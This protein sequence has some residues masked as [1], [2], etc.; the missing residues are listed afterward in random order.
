MSAKPTIKRTV[1]VDPDV[2][3]DLMSYYRVNGLDM[4]KAIRKMM[5]TMHRNLQEQGKLTTHETLKLG[6]PQ[7]G[8]PQPKEPSQ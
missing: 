2:W 5:Q 3:K 6:D 4:S 7:L 8:Q 1:Y